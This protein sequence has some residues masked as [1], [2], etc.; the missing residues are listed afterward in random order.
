MIE[1]VAII[2]GVLVTVAFPIL[3]FAFPPKPRRTRK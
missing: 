2:G 1:A 3:L